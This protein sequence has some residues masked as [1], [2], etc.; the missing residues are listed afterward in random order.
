[1]ARRPTVEEKLA[2]CIEQLDRLLRAEHSDVSPRIREAM[3]EL[4]DA[5]S[6]EPRPVSVDIARQLGRLDEL[7]RGEFA[8]NFQYHIT[9]DGKT[10]AAANVPKAANAPDNRI[11][12][13]N[14]RKH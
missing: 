2:D 11:K 4:L 8:Y 14:K 6:E 13:K 10:V 7:L 3:T 1:M 9:V 5:L 12:P